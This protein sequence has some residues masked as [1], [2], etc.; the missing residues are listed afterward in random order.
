V[1]PADYDKVRETDRVSIVGLDGLA[2]GSEVT[3]VLHHDDG[4]E[5]NIALRHTLNDEQIEWFKAGS[6]LNVL[7]KGQPGS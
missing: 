3:A 2:P 4:S 5:E 7:K 1:D 6:S